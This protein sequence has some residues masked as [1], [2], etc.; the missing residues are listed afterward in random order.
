MLI[1]FTKYQGTGNDFVMIDNRDFLFSNHNNVNL[2]KKLCD[3]RFGIGAD[4]LILLEK[5]GISDFKMVY[6]NSDGQQS[7][8]CGNGGRCLIHFAWKSGIITNETIFE[9]VDGLHLGKILKNGIISLQ[10]SDV[11]AVE[12]RGN[13]VFILNTGSP[14]Y[15]QCVKDMP[16]DI[17]ASGSAIRYSDEF[18]KEGINV[19]FAKLNSDQSIDISTY[20]RGVEDETY[21][22]GTGVTATALISILINKKM[23]IPVTVITKGGKLSVSFK[24]N[25]QGFSDIWLT[26][27]AEKV[28]HGVL[29][30]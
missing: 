11:R 6:F 24:H 15:V 22:C 27:A 13:D 7:T 8:M 17:K 20:E 28:Y 14:H 12:E 16:K 21:S 23:A 2:I 4:G 25:S 18:K 30:I 29:E 26:G 9:A 5:S 10:M 1:K 3:R 19:N